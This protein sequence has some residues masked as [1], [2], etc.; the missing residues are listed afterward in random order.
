MAISASR[1][2]PFD[3]KLEMCRQAKTLSNRAEKTL[4][5][6]KKRFEF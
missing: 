6:G 1:P 3:F 2:H 4:I 5:I